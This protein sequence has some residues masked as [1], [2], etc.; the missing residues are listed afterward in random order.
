MITNNEN[1]LDSDFRAVYGSVDERAN[2]AREVLRQRGQ[3]HRQQRV[4][5]GQERQKF[6][7]STD[8]RCEVRV[9]SKHVRRRRVQRHSERIVAFV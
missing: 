2:T 5:T 6:A 3:S 4:Q 9:G 8:V 1:S 7:D